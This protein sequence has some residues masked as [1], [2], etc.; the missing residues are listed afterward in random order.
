[1]NLIGKIQMKQLPNLYKIDSKGKERIFYIKFNDEKFIT[2][3]GLTNGKHTSRITKPVPKGKNTL[4]EQVEKEAKS[5]WNKKYERELYSLDLTKPHPLAFIQ[6]MAALDYTK[7]PHRLDWTQPWVT[8]AKLNGVRCTVKFENGTATLTSKKGKP[9]TVTH[10]INNFNYLYKLDHVSKDTIFD[11]EL[12]LHNVQLGDVT[13]AVAHDDPALVFKLFD[14]VNENLIFSDRYKKLM[15]MNTFL[16]QTSIDLVPCY[17]IFNEDDLKK[18][19][20][21]YVAG[22]YEGAILR[23]THAYYTIGDRTPGMFKY[24]HFQDAEFDIVGYEA[25]KDGAIILHLLTSNNIVFN[26]RPLGKL[27]YRKQ[28]YKNGK[29]LMGKKATVRFSELL[30]TGV[31]E[32]NRT[33]TIRDYE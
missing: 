23:N 30:K 33:I 16:T 5:K 18:I 10:I 14:M 28:M 27:A 3:A 29:Q 1:M 22:L 12:Y 19:H 8:Q 26:S 4:V 24:K 15:E 31:P 32:F 20:T 25:D 11:G 13:H 9:Y 7:V 17:S 6:P 2:Y 21:K